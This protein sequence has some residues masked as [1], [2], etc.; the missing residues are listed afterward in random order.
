MA[1]ALGQPVFVCEGP[2]VQFCES[3]F[4]TQADSA[5]RALHEC[6]R[7]SVARTS[8]CQWCR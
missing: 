7:V 6:V 3:R 8:C 5:E 1:P 4:S 2:A